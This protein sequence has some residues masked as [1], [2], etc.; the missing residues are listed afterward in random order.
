VWSEPLD[1]VNQYRQIGRGEAQRRGGDAV[2]FDVGRH[3]LVV[4][5]CA[6]QGWITGM[7]LKGKPLREDADECLVL[8]QGLEWVHGGQA[9]RWKSDERMPDSG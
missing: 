3:M 7:R 4:R 8:T 5:V 6:G 9:D 2:T 1:L